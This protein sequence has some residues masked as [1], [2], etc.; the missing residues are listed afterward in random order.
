[1]KTSQSLKIA[2]ALSVTGLILVSLVFWLVPSS[3]DS[4]A[5]QVSDVDD[6]GVDS[7]SQAVALDALVAFPQPASPV[8]PLARLIHA[9][10]FET[11]L[12][13]TG[14]SPSAPEMA[15]LEKLIASYSA[16]GGSGNVRNAALVAEYLRTNPSSP[17]ALSLLQEK[18]AIEW[19]HG[20][21]TASLASVREAWNL[22]M[23]LEGVLERRLAEGALVKL[24]THLGQMGAREELKSLVASVKD[25]ALGG[26][27]TEALYSAKE[28]LWFFENQAEQNIF[29][30]FTAANAI[31]VPAGQAPI[32]P[33]VH[34]DSEKQTFIAKGL[35]I[36]ELQAHN[37]EAGGDFKIYKSTP[38]SNPPVP[39]VIHWKFGHYSAITE[40]AGGLYRVKDFH[41]KFDS[42]VSREAIEVES[43]GYYAVSTKTALPTGLIEVPE[44]E[45]KSIFGRH[46]V[47]GRSDDGPELSTG[48]G[49]GGGEPGGPDGPD[50]PD[51]P[52]CGAPMAV[53]SFRLF[54]PGLEIQDT[55]IAYK[56]PYGPGV[57]IT[58]KYDQRSRAISDIA[59]HSNFGPRWTFDYL[60]YLD[61]T[62][63]GTPASSVRVIF[64]EGSSRV[65]TYSTATGRYAAQYE[66]QPKLEY[67]S[68]TAGGPGYRLRFSNGR[69]WSYLLG[70]S[71]T[72]TR[73]FL[74]SI[75]D[76]RG[77]TLA[78]AYDANLRLTT[79]TDAVGNITT[80]SYTPAAD[81]QFTADIWRVR[82]ITDPFGRTASFR[83]TSTGLLHKIIDPVNIVSEFRYA[84]SGD[85]VDRLTTP[86]GQHAYEWGDLPGINAEPG[87]YIQA[88][89]PYGDRERVEANDFA[90][91]PGNGI[92]PNPAP[93]SIF[94]AGQSISFLPK[95]D[96][97]H[98]RNTFHW[99]KKQMREGAGDYSKAVLYN[100]KA[101]N[102][103]ITGIIGSMKRPLQS[104]VWFNYPGQTDADGLGT[105]MQPSKTVRLVEKDG[106]QTWT[107]V[108]NSYHPASGK[109]NR[110]ID[111]LGREMIYEYNDSGS[112][113][114]AI[115]GL[116]LTAIKVK[117]GTS[118]ETVATFSDYESQQPRTTT[119]AGGQITRYT[120][121]TA[122]Q[123][124]S[125]T[126]AKNETITFSY[127]AADAAGKRRKGRLQ[128]I[129][130][131]LTG[132]ADSVTFDYDSAGRT[133]RVTGPDGYA[134][135]YQY[136]AID[137]LTR[138]TFPDGTFTE[139][140]Y[141]RLDPRTSRD[142]LGRITTYDYNNIRQLHAVTD[143]A[144]RKV[145]YRWCKCGD[146]S[147]LIDAM[148]R[149]TRWLHDVAGRVT[150]KQYADGSKVTFA[151]APHTGRLTGITDPKGQLKSLA[152]NLDGT[153]ASVSYQNAQKPT[154]GV[155]F[156]YDAVYRR[157]TS[158]TDTL[159]TTNYSY[160][161]TT[162][163]TLGAGHLA[164][165]D[166]PWA[167]DTIAYTY[168]ELGRISQRSVG[169]VLMSFA[170]DAAGRPTGVS[171]Q[172]GSFTIGYDGVTSRVL[173][174]T[175]S[176]GQKTEYSYLPAAQDFQ[177]QRI[178]HLKPDGTTPLSVFDYTYDAVGR[179]LSWRQ[180]EGIATA[181][182]RTWAFGYDQADQLTS[183]VA[184][185]GGA[186]VQSYGWSYDPA[187][188]RLTQTLDGASAMT[189]YNA[190]NE[191][192]AT[193]A[194]LPAQ[195][196]E[197]DA[198]DRLLA[199]NQGTSRTE[200]TYDG[201]GRRARLVEKQNGSVVSTK[202][203]L[204]EG[205]SISEQRDASGGTAQQRYFG[206]GYVDLSGGA[207]QSYL[208]TTD[209]LGSI[210]ETTDT[211]GN[212]IQRVSYDF[213]G[214]PS[215][216]SGLV[217]SPFAFTGH[218]R[219]AGSG[220]HLAPYRAY[221]A[222]TGRWISRDPI[223]ESG[224][225]NL[226]SYG[227]NSP[228]TFSDPL[229]LSPGPKA[230]PNSALSRIL[231]PLSDFNAMIPSIGFLNAIRVGND[232]LTVNFGR[233]LRDIVF[234]S[235][236]EGGNIGTIFS[237][238]SF[239]V[240]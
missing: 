208:Q 63:T 20:Y 177:L 226:Y 74:S 58:V 75:S 97:L 131:A 215:F 66:N 159:G 180:Q 121:S 220:L 99:N 163:G 167:N 51:G 96:N 95:T 67:V 71:S 234:G 235:V 141:E 202:S 135:E 140:T 225:I 11:P 216:A 144:R 126:N 17:F 24:L 239:P 171:N 68:Q 164:S 33:D 49:D 77:N 207:P 70:N 173:S 170:F 60:G 35:S 107:M 91:Y 22:G 103:V 101:N 89:D 116:D 72:P 52:S 188:N 138:V 46:C 123:V 132:S 146:L 27:A 166:G 213:W 86:Y 168:D 134:L 56:T 39:S 25:R 28:Q 210:R 157:P 145:Q 154:P 227:A 217:T 224:G 197:W 240:K 161:P 155:S 151:F 54:N 19:K 129:D 182:A 37:H 16:N 231:K 10:A 184:S 92:D 45:A 152:Y 84:A 165:I 6:N 38:K 80:F 193:S 59:T 50:G 73:Y 232:Y 236:P 122:G 156:A 199:I 100:W 79:L 32:F 98:Y 104:R 222:T 192:D 43:S 137:R 23:M 147:Q 118:Y 203:Y 82:S 94:V 9:P 158:M 110:T 21:F 85:F 36:H 124:T 127:Y 53:H 78:F 108:Q 214:N 190:L 189:S 139:T 8:G 181:Q 228:A 219:H 200:F 136:D 229:G 175:H 69:V 142:R 130:G 148:G 172:L 2:A 109:L 117:N 209:H 83:Y 143:P 185:Q 125:I 13:A 105:H 115:T 34:D 42:W 195:T 5:T 12:M 62:G 198:E 87:R 186:T 14:I 133:A 61:L 112:V 187:G 206:G 237:I 7:L 174:L 65:F 57:D 29:C 179:I 119:D 162:P 178:R 169:G 4:K 1:M 111:E 205:L 201:L 18:A 41:L 191:L 90:N 44:A 3:K 114:G 40:S 102:N 113:P 160:H 230:V 88:T 196:Y 194:D 26:L 204:W 106:T 238:A 150:E 212:L 218:F 55:P 30:G 47:H 128:Q 31:C 221:A 15:G 233:E 153:L 93:T 183:A 149:L 120:Y 211:A 64:G 76:P 223:E 48:G 176:G 81:D